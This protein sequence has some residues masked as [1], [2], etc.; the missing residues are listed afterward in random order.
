MRE[1]VLELVVRNHPGAMLHVASLF[2]RRAFNLEGIRCAPVGDGTW[3]AM[4]LWVK[5]DAR[6]PQLVRQLESPERRVVLQVRSDNSAALDLYSTL[7]FRG[8][9]RLA[10][11]SLA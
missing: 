7:G 8:T 6:L 5:E 2:A 4:L 11:F 10:R 1:A 9:R 3:S